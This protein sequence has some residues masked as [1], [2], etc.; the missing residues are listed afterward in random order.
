MI[1]NARLSGWGKSVLISPPVVSEGSV[2]VLAA[3]VM[4]LVRFLGIRATI[5]NKNTISGRVK[6]DN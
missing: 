2:P 3:A 4:P 5:N 6:Y 1:K